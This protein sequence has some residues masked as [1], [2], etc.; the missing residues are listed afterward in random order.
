MR[1]GNAQHGHFA[2][3]R[4]DARAEVIYIATAVDF[5][6]LRREPSVPQQFCFRGYA[7]DQNR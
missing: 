1:L 5:R 2:R 3:A 7:L 4:L 6:C